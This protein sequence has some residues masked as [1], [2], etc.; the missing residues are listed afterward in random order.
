MHIICECVGVG[1]RVCKGECV[2]ILGKDCVWGEGE[3]VGMGW[4]ECVGWVEELWGGGWGVRI[5]ECI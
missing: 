5:C 1:A 4:G 3:C 2:G